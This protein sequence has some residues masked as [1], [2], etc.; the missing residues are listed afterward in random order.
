VPPSKR[1]LAQWADLKYRRHR[2]ESGLFLVEG[3]KLVEE[4][5]AAGWDIEALLAAEGTPEADEGYGVTAEQL[6]RVSGFRTAPEILAV[7]RKPLSLTPPRWTPGTWSLVLDDV[8]DPGNVGT[9]M[10]TAAWFGFDAIFIS[11]A[12]AD[13]W[14]PK[15][16]QASMGAIL[17]LPVGL[18]DEAWFADLPP[19]CPICAGVLDG[20]NVF[21]ADLP[22]QGLLVVGNEGHGVG[23]AWTP[24]IQHLLTVPRFGAETES[25]NVAAAAAVLMAEVRRRPR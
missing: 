10:R 9:L 19:S 16:V 1:E 23:A 22:S 8:Q 25:L 17:R 7:V 6:A 3:R 18:I 21:D 13:P 2:E 5:R 4:T 11:P 20:T 15:A 12:S 24:R 14:G